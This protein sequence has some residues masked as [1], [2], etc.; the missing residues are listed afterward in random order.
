MDEKTA[1]IKINIHKLGE[2]QKI[3]VNNLKQENENLSKIGEKVTVA[4]FKKNFEISS[5][6]EIIVNNSKNETL[7]ETD[8]VGTG[9]KV[10][11]REKTSKKI[12]QEYECI[13]YGDVDGNGKISAM[14]YTLI[15]NHIMEIQAITNLKQK[16]A[17]DVYNDN[18]ISAMD[19]T[20]IQNHIM[21]VQKIELR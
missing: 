2:N 15:Q 8:F 9:A 16:L 12:L 14:D 20:Y 19:Y 5:D 7:K 3:K 17:A 1:S 13:I 4:N 21:E 18:K 11:I 10:Q 6:L